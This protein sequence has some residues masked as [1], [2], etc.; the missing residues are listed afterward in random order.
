MKLLLCFLK[1]PCFKVWDLDRP[2][3]EDAKLEILK[4]DDEEAKQVTHSFF[5]D[6]SYI[7]SFL[8]L[9]YHFLHYGKAVLR[10]SRFLAFPFKLC[11]SILLKFLG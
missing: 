11:Y 2:F 7:I 8:I 9:N 10:G 4:F 6:S 5:V 3:E 1:L